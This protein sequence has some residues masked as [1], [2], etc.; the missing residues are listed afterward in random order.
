MRFSDRLVLRMEMVRYI[1]Y[2]DSIFTLWTPIS[3]KF[4]KSRFWDTNICCSNV[5]TVEFD[6]EIKIMSKIFPDFFLNAV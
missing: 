5:N 2:F 6:T 1:V 3:I 4:L